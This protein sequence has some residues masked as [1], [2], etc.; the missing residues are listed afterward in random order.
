MNA[1][2]N[3]GTTTVSV[4]L[5]AFRFKSQ[6]AKVGGASPVARATHG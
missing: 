6:L 1:I 5:G 4:V 2:G 3:N